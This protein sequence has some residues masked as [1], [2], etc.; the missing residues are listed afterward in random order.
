MFHSPAETDSLKLTESHQCHCIEVH[1]SS[2]LI[3]PTPPLLTAMQGDAGDGGRNYFPNSLRNA[4][5]HHNH[6]VKTNILLVLGALLIVSIPYS[7]L[8][9]LLKL[10][11]PALAGCLAVCL[12]VA[13]IVHLLMT[14]KPS[15]AIH[16]LLSGV[17]VPVLALH[18]CFGGGPESAGVLAA[19][20]L[21]PISAVVLG[22]GNKKATAMVLLI[23]V[24]G[25]IAAVLEQTV[26]PQSVTPKLYQFTEVWHAVFFFVN[27]N[28]SQLIAFLVVA[29]A[30]QQLQTGRRRL[31]ESKQQVD[32]LNANLAKQKER[33]EQEQRLTQRLIHHVF[34]KNMSDALIDFVKGCSQRP[35]N[36]AMCEVVARQA[37]RRGSQRAPTSSNLSGPVFVLPATAEVRSGRGSIASVSTVPE[38]PHISHFAAAVAPTLHSFAVVLFAHISGFTALSSKIDPTTLIHFLDQFFG[39]IDDYC[40]DHAVEKIKTIGDCY[41][42]VAWEE[43]P[44][45]RSRCAKRVLDVAHRMHH[46]AHNNLVGKQRLLVRAGIHAGPVISGII[47]R[48]KFAFD[49]WGDTVNVAS[50]MESTGVPGTTQVTDEVYELLRSSNSFVPRGL[51]EVKGKGELLTYTTPLLQTWSP[52]PEL[53]ISSRSAHFNVVDVLTSLMQK[54][55]MPP[56]SSSTQPLLGLAEGCPPFSHPA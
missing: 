43:E 19:A 13:A 20:F 36:G 14:N 23:V 33:L 35:D 25:L 34:P 49:I 18:L 9:F 30:Y 2:L 42:C 26:G 29:Q 22:L 15:V 53:V 6:D 46:M 38:Q 51:V 11:A 40:K 56:S 28:V 3:R 54:S 52:S 55:N 24:V 45:A 8:L 1:L 16:I 21:A 47:G 37:W 4:S 5:Q 17:L 41:M 10:E 32:S 7:L 44:P 27:I 48:T 50:R 39:A 12:F 31:Q